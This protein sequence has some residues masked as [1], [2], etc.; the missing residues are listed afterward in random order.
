M[1]EEA[2][3]DAVWKMIQPFPAIY[4]LK[5]N[6]GSAHMKKK[7]III[8]S[9]A[10]VGVVLLGLAKHAMDCIWES[11]PD[12]MSSSKAK[13]QTLI[14]VKFGDVYI[15]P[16]SDYTVTFEPEESIPDGTF[17]ELTAK[18]EYLFGGIAGYMG[19]PSLSKVY[20]YRTVSADELS[21]PS[22]Y[23]PKHNCLMEIGDY[24]GGDYLLRSRGYFGVYKDGKWLYK[25]DTC[26]PWNG[27]YEVLCREGVTEETIKTGIEK[28]ILCCE[29]YF[30]RP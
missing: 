6:R 12:A 25:Y 22:I 10:L 19:C 26:M 16:D 29:D 11:S 7:L 24:A 21:F 18:V 3:F 30:V 14:L 28:G 27:A 15:D 20:S 23:G 9:V 4:I 17:L 13:K 2:S 1:R 5:L 8:F